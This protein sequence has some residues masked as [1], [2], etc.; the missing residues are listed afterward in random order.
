LQQHIGATNDALVEAGDIVLKGQP[1]GESTDPVSAPVHA[2]TSG[3]VTFV[4][5]QPIPHPSG[6]SGPCV[7]ISADGQ[8]KWIE[9]PWSIADYAQLRPEQI[10]Q[11]VRNA[12][13][14]GLGGA[15]FPTAVKMIPGPN[16]TVDTLIINGTE[17]EPYIGCDDALMRSRPVE[18][19]A[20]IQILRHGMSA[21]H[22]II[23]V[24]DDKPESIAGLRQA[25]NAGNLEGIELVVVP[26]VYPSGGE[27]QLIKLL[28]GQEVPS[29]GLP[30]DIGMLCFNVATAQTVYRAITQGEPLVSR[31][32]TVTGQGVAEPGNLEAL[33]GTPFSQ[34]VEECGGYTDQ[35]ARLIMGGS[36]MGVALNNDALPVVKATNCLL[37]G[38]AAEST[39]SGP[40]M[41][42]IRCGACADACPADLLPQQL[43]W[44]TRAK[45]FDKAQD[46][47]LFDCIECGCC[48]YV[49]PSNIP[50]VQYYRFA[51]DEI[52]TGERNRQRADL[53]RQRFESR[54]ARLERAA[55]EKAAR[56]ARKR[57]Q[58]HGTHDSTRDKRATQTAIQAALD[59][60][61]QKRTRI[62]ENNSSGCS[63]KP[64]PGPHPGQTAE[65]TGHQNS[66]ESVHKAD[67]APAEEDAPSH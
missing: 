15:V 5:D 49:C 56:L 47:H 57:A 38:S 67:E 42:C 65:R 53:A 24:E 17:C 52:W 36:M 43:Y 45:D 64:Q 19:L 63:A 40:V 6:V 54:Q 62:S 44:Y 30:A 21:S 10:R 27:K 3:R 34:L 31:V 50:L 28:T 35:A 22:C 41:P 13:I 66:P 9:R 39:S 48:S 11:R 18:I 29:G 61:K 14:V 16:K 2:P 23:G 25:I 55:Q 37:V 33:I 12:G 7:V 20:G 32:V 26:T 46:L 1:I 59:R 51:K 8:D 4:G 60:V 58:L